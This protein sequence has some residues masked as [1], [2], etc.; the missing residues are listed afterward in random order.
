[1]K[2]IIAIAFDSPQLLTAVT[3]TE[4]VLPASGYTVEIL[5]D[6]LE[7]NDKVRFLVS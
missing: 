3:I 2:C 5:D 7:G 4:V 1:M 6:L